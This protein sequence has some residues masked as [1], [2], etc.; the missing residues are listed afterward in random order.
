MCHQVQGR[1][2][3]WRITPNSIYSTTYNQTNC[4]NRLIDPS[5]S[6]GFNK[7]NEIDHMIAGEVEHIIRVEI[8]T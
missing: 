6:D 7:Q 8:C 2:F 1:K 5:F 3:T 4:D